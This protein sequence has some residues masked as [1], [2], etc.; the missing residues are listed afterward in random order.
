MARRK[1]R[2]TSVQLPP[3]EYEIAVEETDWPYFLQTPLRTRRAQ[4]AADKQRGRQ[5]TARATSKRVERKK[6]LMPIIAEEAAKYRSDL[7]DQRVGELIHKDVED[8]AG[9]KLKLSTL[10][11]Y[12]GIVRAQKS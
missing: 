8:R 12:T 9:R 6:G 5:N 11:K 3:P 4:E 10:V 7:S 2:R 1:Q